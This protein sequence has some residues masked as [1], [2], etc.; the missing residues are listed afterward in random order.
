M[1]KMLSR[2]PGKTLPP[3]E[4][5]ERKGFSCRRLWI[6][7]IFAAIHAI[8]ILGPVGC[9]WLAE[10]EDK[11]KEIAFRVDLGGLE[12]SHA[13]EV[14]E[15]ERLR[16]GNTPPP[17]EP[18]PE[19]DPVPPASEAI[20]EP[21]KP[22]PPKPDPEPPKPDPAEKQRKAEIEK[23]KKL[24]ADKQR[25]AEIEKKKKL[26]ADKKRKA[27]ADRKK[28]LEADKKRKADADRQRKIEESRIRNAEIARKRKEEADRKR[29]ENSVYRDPNA[30]KFDPNKKYT[31]GTNFNKNVKIGKRDAGQKQGKVDG[32][33][34]AGG[35]DRGS[36][37]EWEEFSNTLSG[38]IEDKWDE[39]PGVLIN[40]QT[41]AV[42]AIRVDRNGRVIGKKLVK[43]SP[44][45]AVTSSANALLKKLNTLPRPPGN[46]ETGWLEIVLIPE[47]R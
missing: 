33:T 11:Q 25:K 42:I 46:S 32:R 21:P 45:P 1:K 43:S 34:P 20:P 7:L 38:I 2:T 19:N 12:P 23:K 40:E 31:G 26:E 30:D 16:P 6:F 44:N 39:P 13:P 5:E 3:A 22:D 4:D 18:E 28:K 37:K 29:R 24:E 35:A 17:S 15:P 14:G 27:E 47:G 9:F 10:D 41:A 36:E 8:V